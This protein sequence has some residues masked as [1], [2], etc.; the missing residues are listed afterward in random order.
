MCFYVGPIHGQLLALF[1]LLS[2]SLCV[3]LLLRVDVTEQTNDDKDD[4]DDDDNLC[5]FT[6]S[7]LNFLVDVGRRLCSVSA[8]MRL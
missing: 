5:V 8:D 2:S 4:D 3:Y 7:T 1:A 6:L